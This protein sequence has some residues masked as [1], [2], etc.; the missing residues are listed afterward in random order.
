MLTV[1]RTKE[2]SEW[3]AALADP[4]GR[5]A[6]VARIVRLELGNVGDAKSVG[7][8]VSELRVDVGPGYRVYMTRTG[9]TLQ[10]LLCGGDKSSQEADINR[11]QGIV[12]ELDKTKKAAKATN[13]QRKK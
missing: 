6:I 12:E 4:I 2:F 9:A 13:K 10:L 5:A 11:A 3:L 1:Q 8:K 7:G